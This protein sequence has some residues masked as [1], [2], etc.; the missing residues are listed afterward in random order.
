MLK[1]TAIAIHY[2]KHVPW[3]SSTN[4][5][6]CERLSC[7]TGGRLAGQFCYGYVLSSTAAWGAGTAIHSSCSEQMPSAGGNLKQ[8]KTDLWATG[9]S[10][11]QVTA[12]LDK[13]SWLMS[14]CE[15]PRNFQVLMSLAT[16]ASHCTLHILF[17]SSLVLLYLR[18]CL[19]FGY[20]LLERNFSP[21]RL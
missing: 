1:W 3:L 16:V 17:Y 10:T 20:R 13:E 9:Q 7:Q 15:C 2:I 6:G 14:K 4:L 12:G 11:R 19:R 21:Q 5:P 18:T 8:P